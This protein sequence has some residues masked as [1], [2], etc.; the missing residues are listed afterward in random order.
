[1]P[2][3][4]GTA[5]RNFLLSLLYV[6]EKPLIAEY[7][8]KKADKHRLNHNGLHPSHAVRSPTDFQQQAENTDLQH[9]L[10]DTPK[11]VQQ[12]P[13]QQ[14]ETPKKMYM[15]SRTNMKEDDTWTYFSAVSKNVL[16]QLDTILINYYLLPP[17]TLKADR[18]HS[19]EIF[20][21]ISSERHHL[22]VVP[23]YT[24]SSTQTAVLYDICKRWYDAFDSL[25]RIDEKGTDVYHRLC[26]LERR[27]VQ[28][29]YPLH[30][31]NKGK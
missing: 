11:D 13:F 16:G 24:L 17:K 5:Q 6:H 4:Y 8:I 23:P 19:L 12:Q 29:K 20:T 22:R 1:M 27:Y 21:M 9:R 30:L 10:T 2:R 31:N 15:W 7:F 26:D 25:K 3:Y 14:E 28:G 18:F